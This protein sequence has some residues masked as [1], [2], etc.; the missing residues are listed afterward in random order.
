MSMGPSTDQPHDHSTGDPLALNGRPRCPNMIVL[1]R[2]L[3]LISEQMPYIWRGFT[4][5]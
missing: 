3:E 1:R 5:S 2:L 4:F